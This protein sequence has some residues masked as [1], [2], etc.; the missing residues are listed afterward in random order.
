MIKR[1]EKFNR[2]G[3]MTLVLVGLLSAATAVLAEED[4]AEADSPDKSVLLDPSHES[5]NRQ[6]PDVFKVKFKTTKGDVVI[7]VT[8]EWAPLGADRFYNLADN[9][10]YDGCKFFRVIRGEPQDFMAQFGI[11]GDP[12]VSAVWREQPIKDDPNKQSNTHGR[13]TFAMSGPDT[14]TTQLF[15]TYDDNSFLDSQGFSPFGEVVEGMDVI[16]QLYA[17]YGEG[18]PRGPGPDQGR[19]QHEGNPYLNADFPRLDSIISARVVD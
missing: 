15:I 10:F 19:V 14:R 12:E 16:D 2:F 11:N 4:T 1:F 9:G 3:W 13:V 17:D 18:A 6:A 8:R 7:Q 5:W